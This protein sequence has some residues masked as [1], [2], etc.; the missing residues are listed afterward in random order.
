MDRQDIL[1]WLREDDE[2]RLEELWRLADGTR[3]KHV[4]DA[5]HLRGLI[6]ISNYCVRPCAYCGLRAAHKDIKKVL[7]IGVNLCLAIGTATPRR[8]NE[9]PISSIGLINPAVGIVTAQGN[10]RRQ[11]LTSLSGGLR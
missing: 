10:R 11:S 4:G 2:R 5:V 7:C 8:R 9:S 6:E 1:T 3:S